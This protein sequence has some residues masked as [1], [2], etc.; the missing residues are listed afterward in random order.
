[1]SIVKVIL[2]ILS[3]LLLV[4]LLDSKIGPLPPVGKFINPFQGV[5]QNALVD[6]FD[7]GEAIKLMGMRDEA[8]IIFDNR[9]VPHIFSNNDHDLYFLQ[10]YV[11]AR[12]RLWQME[13]Q[14]HA[15]AG[16]LSEIVGEKTLNFDLEQRRIGMVWAAEQSLAEVWK[17]SLSRMAIEA[18]TAGVNAY[19]NSL[20][21]EKW[22]LEYKL[23]DYG[24]EQW[25]HLKCALLMKYMA[26]MLT[27][28]ERDMANSEALK[29]LGSDLFAFLYPEQNLLEDPIVADFVP[30]TSNQPASQ[31]AYVGGGTWQTIDPQPAYVGSNNW[32]V[33]GSRTASG[34]AILCNDPHLKLGLPSIWYEV[35]LHAPGINCYGVSL[36]GAPGV[37]IGYNNRVAWG[38]TNAGR[39]VKD[40][41]SITF[42]DKQRKQ[43]KYGDEWRATTFR[44]EKLKVRGASAVI[45]T[46]VY[47]HYGP[48]AHSID[49]SNN[50][51]A[52]RWAAHIPSNELRTFYGLNRANGYAE[53]LKAIK[54][55]SCPGQNFVFADITDTIAIWQQGN[56]INR[57]KGHGRFILDGS[58]PTNDI[59]RA[60]PQHHNPHMVNPARGF[61]SSANQ[62]PTGA[63]YP[64]YYTGVFEEFRNR[65]INDQLRKE[66][67]ATVQS[68]MNLQNS[69]FNLLAKEA[70]PLMLAM[71][72]TTLF[73]NK[74]VEM[75]A[76]DVLS[77]WNYT[78]DRG[79]ISPTIFEIWWDEFNSLL[80]DELN[81]KKWNQEQYY[82][83]SWEEFGK[84]HKAYLDLRDPR[85]VYPMAKVIIDL[86]TK[87]PS[88]AIFDH[89]FT[90][91]KK[92][93]AKDLVYDAF[94]WTS[95][96]LSDIITY[97]FAKPQ[98]GHYQATRIEHLLRMEALSSPALFVGGSKHAPNATTSS[99]GPSWR[100]VVELHPDGPKGYGVLPGGQSGNPA[101]AGYMHSLMSWVKGEYHELIFLT[102]EDLHSG[103]WKRHKVMPGKP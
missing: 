90:P 81:D 96:K 47:T 13:L 31:S 82:R 54:Y 65:T 21:R 55:F 14:T 22:P 64:Y 102:E 88:A 73:Q 17:D 71:L 2:G 34:H 15:A 57:P 20:T 93:T 68:M 92:E 52:L 78:N 45:D 37:V 11:T 76:F 23:L 77:N 58:D 3:A 18:Y 66:G 26:K 87:E 83:Y 6:T 33:S 16:R 10:G 30:D 9:D 103:K 99:H 85:Y 50:Y 8:E 49:S 1:M 7:A 94:Y 12:D 61:V 56:F 40:Y 32:A 4:V 29:Y 69:N 75:M 27:G 42:K 74:R 95:M 84:T 62:A 67:K 91:D 98:W 59:T 24:P 46:V 89:H 86:L 19:I 51:L 5:W 38:V 43:Y 48:V 79:I 35:Q 70:L 63:T 41:F 97:D 53:Y 25:T 72:D 39:D 44:V 28:S 60:I 100:M 36:P 80:W 101:N